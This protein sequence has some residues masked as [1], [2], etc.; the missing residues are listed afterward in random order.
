MME[1][2]NMLGLVK[3]TGREHGS[4]YNITG[5]RLGLQAILDS[6]HPRRRV[7]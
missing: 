5:Y 6:T 3:E 7:S 1:Y 4:Y 2:G